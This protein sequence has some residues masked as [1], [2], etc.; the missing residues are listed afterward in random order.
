MG[1]RL[2]NVTSRGYDQSK[3]LNG[4]QLKRRET[5]ILKS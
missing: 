2:E 5:Y 3:K 4:T 1:E